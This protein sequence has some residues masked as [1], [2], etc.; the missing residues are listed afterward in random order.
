MS[1]L[2]LGSLVVT[3]RTVASSGLTEK[4]FGL[5]LVHEQIEMSVDGR[6]YNRRQQRHRRGDGTAPSLHPHHH[7]RP[8]SATAH[9]CHRDSDWETAAGRRLQR[10]VRAALCRSLADTRPAT[11]SHDQL[12]HGRQT[13]PRT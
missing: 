12:S 4:S 2:G 8:V 10:C 6:Q 13:E 9:N 5:G 11:L 1:G 7:Y 3:D